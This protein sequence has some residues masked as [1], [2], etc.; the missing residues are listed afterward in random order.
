MPTRTG[1][2]RGQRVAGRCSLGA[3]GLLGGLAAFEV[4]LAAGAPWGEAAFGGGEANLSAGLRLAA[5]A[6]V[7][8]D[9]A[10]ALVLLRRG[11]HRVWALL[12]QRWLP[13]AAWVLTGYFGLGTVLNAASRSPVE[14]NLMVPTALALAALSACVAGFGER[15]ARGTSR[16][17]AIAAMPSPRPVS[18]SP[19][20]VVAET[21]TG[22]ETAAPRMA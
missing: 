4:A 17:V 7:P 9:I 16:A 20:V 11:G 18:P 19:S 1:S 2:E 3:A 13:P 15:Q 14:R 21:D 8:L 22:A 12:P 10:I 6:S 5:A